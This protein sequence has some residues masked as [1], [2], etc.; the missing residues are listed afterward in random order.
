MKLYFAP[1]TRAVRPRWLLE[2]LEASYELVKLDAAEQRSPAYLSVNPLGEVPTLVDGDVTLHE[3][4]AICLHLADRFGEKGLAPAPG[5][6][7]R[8]DYL[9]WIVFAETQLDSVVMAVLHEPSSL[10]LHHP[11]FTRVLD[12][13]DARLNGRQTLAG[14]RFS[15]ADLSTASLL[16]LA[17]NL[18]LLASYPRL[19]DY[20]ARHCKGPA[21]MRAVAA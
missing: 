13:L 15:A 6:R 1:R 12:I 3:T 4:L 8:G 17:K 14:E 7:E 20:V 21:L 16:H 5:S 2:E 9:Q 18:N 11:R 19:V 10:P